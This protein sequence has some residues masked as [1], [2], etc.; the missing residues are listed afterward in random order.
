MNCD[1]V[2][3]GRVTRVCIQIRSSI[4]TC[5]RMGCDASLVVFGQS[6]ACSGVR[7][8]EVQRGLFKALPQTRAL[9]VAC[10]AMLP[11]FG[12]GNAGGKVGDGFKHVLAAFLFFFFRQHGCDLRR[13]CVNIT[14][15]DFHAQLL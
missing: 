11:I 7:T 2:L 14:Q 13:I 9:F 8:I 3:G 10:V 4:A 6:F 12:V 15:F 1:L 5:R